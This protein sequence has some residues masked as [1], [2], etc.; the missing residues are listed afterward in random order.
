MPLGSLSRNSS[1][2]VKESRVPLESPIRTSFWFWTSEVVICMGGQQCLFGS[3]VGV[4]VTPRPNCIWPSWLIGLVFHFRLNLAALTAE[5]GGRESRVFIFT[6]H[7]IEFF[8]VVDDWRNRSD[9]R[10]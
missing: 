8:V 10:S 6:G 5:D 4:L 3:L 9:H 7:C 1:I 2:K